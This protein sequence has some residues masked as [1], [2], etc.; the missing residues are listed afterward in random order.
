PL[1]SA[2]LFLIVVLHTVASISRSQ[3]TYVL[4][5]LRVV[6]F[7]AFTFQS[8]YRNLSPAQH[9]FL[10]SVPRDVRTAMKALDLEPEHTIYACC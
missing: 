3:A 5:T 6:I 1:L 10:N 4:S 2:I 8:L 9:A 7:S